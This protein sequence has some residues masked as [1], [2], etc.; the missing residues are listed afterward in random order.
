[1]TLH[2]ARVCTVDRDR[3]GRA[4]ANL[5]DKARIGTGQVLNGNRIGVPLWEREYDV[6]I[7]PIPRD[8]RDDDVV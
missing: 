1:V 6:G 7:A 8:G 2:R 4:D 3:H 5:F